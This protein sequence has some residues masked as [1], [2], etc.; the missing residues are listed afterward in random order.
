MNIGEKSHMLS[1]EVKGRNHFKTYQNI[2]F[3]FKKA[4]PK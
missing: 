1:M 3:F 2:L 4:C